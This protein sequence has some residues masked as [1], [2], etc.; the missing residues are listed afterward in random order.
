ME[1]RDEQERYEQG[2]LSREL[3]ADL[4]QYLSNLAIE[5]YTQES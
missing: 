1:A 5:G 4:T 3:P 2:C